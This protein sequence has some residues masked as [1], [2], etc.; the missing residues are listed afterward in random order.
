MHSYHVGCGCSDPKIFYNAVK[1]A[2]G[3]FDEAVS[4]INLVEFEL[5]QSLINILRT[6][7]EQR[8]RRMPTRF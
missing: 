1:D 6:D 5:M 4:L 8:L 7:Q 2:R 3:V